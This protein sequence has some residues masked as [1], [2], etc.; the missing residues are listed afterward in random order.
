M[1]DLYNRK[2]KLEYWIQ[3]IYTDLK[4]NEPDKNDVLKFVTSLQEKD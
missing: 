3:R 2:A 1:R 4:D